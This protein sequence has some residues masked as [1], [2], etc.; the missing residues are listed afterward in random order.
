[1]DEACKL[2]PSLF[3]YCIHWISTKRIPRTLALTTMAYDSLLQERIT[4]RELM[5]PYEPLPKDFN[6]VTL[7]QELDV[8]TE[9]VDEDGNVKDGDEE[10]HFVTKTVTINAFEGF[11][12]E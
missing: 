4:F 3:C 1:M 5:E 8:L 12:I 6:I 9:N 2:D 7:G 11:V 10:D